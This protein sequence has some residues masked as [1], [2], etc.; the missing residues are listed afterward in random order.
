LPLIDVIL[1]RV[2]SPALDDWPTKRA[3]WQTDDGEDGDEIGVAN[4]K[5][6]VPRTASR[7]QAPPGS[8]QSRSYPRKKV[9]KKDSRQSASLKYTRRLNSGDYTS[10]PAND[11][12]S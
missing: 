4:I 9:Y 11:A 1:W 5:I 2:T 7:G 12:G 8:R 10:H 3:E 6:H